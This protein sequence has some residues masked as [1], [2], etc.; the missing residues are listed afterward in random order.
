M[1]PRCNQTKISYRIVDYR[2]Q[3][4]QCICIVVVFYLDSYDSIKHLL[5]D[6]RLA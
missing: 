3:N 6:E 1:E 4:N 5:N 2:N